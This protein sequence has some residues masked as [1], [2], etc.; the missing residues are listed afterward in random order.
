MFLSLS[1]SLSIHIIYIYKILNIFHKYIYTYTYAGHI[2]I[3]IHI[4]IHICAYAWYNVNVPLN[5]FVL[6]QK[7]LHL[8]T[9]VELY[10]TLEQ[11]Y[12]YERILKSTTFSFDPPLVRNWA[13]L[14]TGI[15]ALYYS[16]AVIKSSFLKSDGTQKY[17]CLNY[18]NIAISVF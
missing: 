15:A 8:I 5:F 11:Q 1:I 3:H 7:Y 4:H 10:S 12:T 17:T 6:V 14:G 9:F 2:Q 13:R 18:E 16:S